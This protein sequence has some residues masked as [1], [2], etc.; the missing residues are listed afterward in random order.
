MRHVPTRRRLDGQRLFLAVE[1]IVL[2]LGGPL[3][4]NA[5]IGGGDPLVTMWLLTGLALVL[6]A[7]TPGFRWSLLLK[8]ME[9]AD[10]AILL[11]GGVLA[12]AACV[13]VVLI[14]APEQIGRIIRDHFGLWLVVVIAY[15]IISAL[16]QEIMYRTLFFERYGALMPSPMVAILLNGAAFAFAH[17][18]M[19][20]TVTLIVTSISGAYIGWAY[21][22]RH[23]LVLSVLL[24]GLAG[25]IAFTVGLGRYLY[26]GA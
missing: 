24:H 5:H 22:R 12:A 11:I 10:W 25:D 19:M 8:G 20:S 16:P 13:A 23:S 15:P 3:L 14:V 1:F 21:L 4:I 9:R 18:F 17:L 26:N 6:L 7:L 2:F